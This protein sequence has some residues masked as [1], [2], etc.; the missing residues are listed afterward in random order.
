[1][2]HTIYTRNDQDIIE[3]TAALRSVVKKAINAALDYQ[4][5]DFPCEISVTFT[6]NDKI[7]ELNR[8]YRGKDAPT[9]VLSFPMFEAGEIEYDDESGEPCALGDIVISLERAKAQSEEYG[10]SLEREAAFLAVHSVLHLLGFDHE[11]SEEDEV[12]MKESAEEILAGIGLSRPGFESDGASDKEPA[13][14]PKIPVKEQ[15]TMFVS[16][17][18]RPNVGKST[19]LN[20]MVGEKVAAVSKKPQTTRNRITGILTKDE[21]QFVFIDTPGLHKPKNKLGEFMVNAARE[22]IPDAD[23]VLFVAEVTDRIPD[24]DKQIMEKLSKSKIPAILVLNKTDI[25]NKGKLL[26]AIARYSSMC[27]FASV[28]PASALNGENV[29]IILSELEKFIRNEPWYFPD[30]V[31]TDQPIRVIAAEII[32]EK[33]LRLLDD[34]IPHGTAVTIEDYEETERLVKIRAEIYCEK[35]AHKK[36]IIGKGGETLKKAATY[37]R[38]DIDAMIGKK[39]FLDLWVKV[40]ENW[41]DSELNIERFGFKKDE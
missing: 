28:V 16:I 15:K 33:L 26:E 1:M 39:V 22:S 3:L 13:E 30:D 29:D 31:A 27:E 25:T 12:Y 23:A 8:K 34:E 19:L 9:D 35:A 11:T 17:I 6:D 2:K 21:K 37:A 32:R 38:E 4:E 41:R 5:I 7:H 18:G 20:A 36:I 10:H 40:K 14:T 24:Q